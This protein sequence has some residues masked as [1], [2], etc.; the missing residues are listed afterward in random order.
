VELGKKSAVV[1][2]VQKV[3]HCGTGQMSPAPEWRARCGGD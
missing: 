1:E 3:C 2:L